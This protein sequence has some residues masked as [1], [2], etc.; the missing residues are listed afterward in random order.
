MTL[1][2]TD[3]SLRRTLIVNARLKV[4]DVHLK[5]DCSKVCWGIQIT[6]ELLSI[7]LS[8][9]RLE[10]LFKMTFGIVQISEAAGLS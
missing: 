8:K 2:K 6:E 7:L 5:V 4:E 3:I 1:Y 9:R 10:G